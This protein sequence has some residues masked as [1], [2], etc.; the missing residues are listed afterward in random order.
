MTHLK[1]IYSDYHTCSRDF[2]DGLEYLKERSIL[3]AERYFEQALAS[4]D[5][6]DLNR[7][8]YQSYYGF[9]R[10]LNGYKDGM[11]LC[12]KALKADPED[13]DLYLNLA[14]ATLF[15]GNREAA[16]EILDQ[17]LLIE[18][19]H[20]GLLELKDEI[21]YRNHNPIPIL[22]RNNPVNEIIGR[23]IRKPG[24]H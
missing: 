19:Y 7:Y 6:N 12:K 14:R 17:G 2:M 23:F 13:G 24:I 20:Q 8:K 10:V 18:K 16:V 15:N 9:S 1:T 22:K 11:E 21:G 4:A 5:A 3:T